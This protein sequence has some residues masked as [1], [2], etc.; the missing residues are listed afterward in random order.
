VTVSVVSCEVTDM[1]MT[2]V[3]RVVLVAVCG[4]SSLGCTSPLFNL[5]ALMLVGM[6]S[7]RVQSEDNTCVLLAS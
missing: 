2:E 5:I 3:G 7:P 6:L 1:G 4:F